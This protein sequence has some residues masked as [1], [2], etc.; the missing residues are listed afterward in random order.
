MI[1]F[2]LAGDLI[3]DLLPKTAWDFLIPSVIG[4]VV[5]LLIL[6]QIFKYVFNIDLLE[7]LF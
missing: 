5:V 3:S 2:I 4:G 7:G 1:L 6:I